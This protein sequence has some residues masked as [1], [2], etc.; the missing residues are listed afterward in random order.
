MPKAFRCDLHIHTCLSP[1]AELDM[2][3]RSI[4]ERALEKK[5]DVIGICDHNA[6]ENVIFV[7]KAAKDLPIVVLPGMELTS[8]EEV[9]TLALFDNL[10]A[11]LMIQD[12]VYQHLPGK[13]DED[14]FGC[15][16]VVNERDEVEGFNEHLLIGATDFPLMTL[17]GHI[18]ELGGLA[19]ASHID[20]ESFSAISQLGF[21]SDDMP[22]DALEI[23]VRTGLQDARYQFP[24]L[25][26]RTFIVSSDAHFVRDIGRGYTDIMLE[27]VSVKELKMAF[28]HQ[29][30]RYVRE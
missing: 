19:I 26:R 10:E 24:D 30:G 27:E 11:L 14:I 15:Q 21:I 7:Q 28:E 13:N 16:A 22:F 23:S 18:H 17:I 3:P 29:E 12:L 25:V 9:H 4:I 20:R 2:Y 6:C 5:L 8:R 1:C